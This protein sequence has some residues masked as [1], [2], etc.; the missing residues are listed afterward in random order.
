KL[1]ARFCAR[2]QD[3]RNLMIRKPGNNWRNH[4]ANWN[5]CCTK[6]FDG[7]ESTLRRGRARFEHA[8]QR[9]IERRYGN[10]DRRGIARRELA[11][12]IDVARDEMV[13][14][15]DRHR[16]AKFCEHFEAA[17]R[18]LQFSLDRLI[19]ISHTAQHERLRLP[20]WRFQLR[21]Q[22]LRRI[23]FPHDFAFEIKTGR[24]PQILVSRSRVTIDATV[25]AP[26]I[27][28]QARFK[29]NIRT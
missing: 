12:N 10:V 7:V 21:T 29:T 23:G 24:K 22:Q 1:R 28:V 18:D 20:P 4:Y 5:F 26:P 15:N 3:L 9:W 11:Q 16:I 14:C 6:L 13:L 2:L 25:L 27:R 19:W 17:G 8:L